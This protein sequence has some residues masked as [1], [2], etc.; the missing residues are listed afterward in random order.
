MND[1]N[2]KLAYISAQ[3][4]STI[5]K[6]GHGEFGIVYEGKLLKYNKTVKLN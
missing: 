2:N 6:I 5:K 3:D 1:E 4:L